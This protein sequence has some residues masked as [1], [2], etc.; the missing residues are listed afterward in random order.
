MITFLKDS[1]ETI[2]ETIKETETK[3]MDTLLLKK[4]IPIIR[5]EKNCGFKLT[6]SISL[7]RSQ[8]FFFFL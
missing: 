1:D 3:M 5:W 4:S 7:P 6:I 8:I 2:L